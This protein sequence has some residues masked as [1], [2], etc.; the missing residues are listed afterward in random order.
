MRNGFFEFAELLKK[1]PAEIKIPSVFIRIHGIAMPAGIAINREL[2]F[3]R[4]AGNHGFFAKAAR[5]PIQVHF[6]PPCHAPLHAATGAKRW[7]GDIHFLVKIPI[8]I[9]RLKRCGAVLTILHTFLI[10]RQREKCALTAH[11]IPI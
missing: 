4:I 5:A 10:G 6:I 2:L 3:R 1:R 11:I 7:F 8:G 9:G